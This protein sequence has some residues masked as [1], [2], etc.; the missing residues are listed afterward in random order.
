MQV[1]GI[2]VE[3][4]DSTLNIPAAAY[5]CVCTIKMQYVANLPSKPQ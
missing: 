4:Q 5:A 2:A 1:L 3:R